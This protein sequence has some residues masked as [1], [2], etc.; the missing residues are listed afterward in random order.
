MTWLRI[1]LFFFFETKN[2][3]FSSEL[4]TIERNQEGLHQKFDKQL[5]K[6]F[7]PRI[8]GIVLQ[9]SVLLFKTDIFSNSETATPN[10]EN[11]F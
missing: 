5:D 1:S 6:N 8:I 4:L 2:R 11:K 9:T 3:P 7:V 10:N